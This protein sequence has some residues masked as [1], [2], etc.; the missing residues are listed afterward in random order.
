MEKVHFPEN[1]MAI[2]TAEQYL[3]EAA[4]ADGAVR[5]DLLDIAQCWIEAAGQAI[6]SYI[7]DTGNHFLV[8]HFNDQQ[9][10]VILRYRELG[11]EGFPPSDSVT[12]ILVPARALSPC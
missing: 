12:A 4:V 7:K 8:S 9:N 1:L 10:E 5:E 3:R 2:E 6:E 11:G